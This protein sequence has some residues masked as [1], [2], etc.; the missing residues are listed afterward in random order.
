VSKMIT[1]TLRGGPKN[2]QVKKMHRSTGAYIFLTSNG[3]DGIYRRDGE[4]TMRFE[5]VM[6]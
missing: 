4:K 3:K 2:G 5:R 6:P 1:F